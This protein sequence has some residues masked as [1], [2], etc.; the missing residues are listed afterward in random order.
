MYVLKQS[1]VKL[2]SSSAISL[3]H[4]NRYS[5]LKFEYSM[6]FISVS[7]FPMDSNIRNIHQCIYNFANGDSL[8]RY[9]HF[10]LAF[11]FNI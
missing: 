6:I 2:I 11:V 9:Y 4:G 5:T 3:S 8:R 7:L 1:L 10:N